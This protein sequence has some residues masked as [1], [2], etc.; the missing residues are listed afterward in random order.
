MILINKKIFVHSYGFGHWL[1]NEYCHAVDLDDDDGGAVNYDKFQPW[2]LINK[3]IFV[4][5]YGDFFILFVMNIPRCP[6]YRISI[7]IGIFGYFI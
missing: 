5:S 1:V 3:K 6:E 2:I 7:I 4:H